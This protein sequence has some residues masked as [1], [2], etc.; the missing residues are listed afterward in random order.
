[1]LAKRNDIEPAFCYCFHAA[2]LEKDYSAA[3]GAWV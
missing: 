3:T 2:A 1:M